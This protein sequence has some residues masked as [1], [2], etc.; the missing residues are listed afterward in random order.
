MSEWSGPYLKLSETIKQDAQFGD[1]DDIEFAKDILKKEKNGTIRKMQT[2]AAFSDAQIFELFEKDKIPSQ[3]WHL[4][5]SYFAFKELNGEERKYNRR[6]ARPRY[7][8]FRNGR[9]L[10][11]LSD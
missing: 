4:Y 1:R 6:I 11:R 10:C 9:G 3:K 5:V 2:F 8:F 7:S